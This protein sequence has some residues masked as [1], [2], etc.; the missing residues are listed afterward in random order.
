MVAKPAVRLGHAGHQRPLEPP[1]RVDEA[2]ELLPE[3]CT[4]CHTVFPD[5]LPTVAD[6]RRTQVWELP[7]VPPHLTEYRQ[8]TR[9]CPACRQLVTA[10]LPADAPPGGFGPRATALI[11]LLRGRF[12]LSL[13]DTV[14]CLT[15]LWHLPLCAASVVTRCARV[16]AALAPLDAAIQD[17]VQ[18]APV[19]NADETSWPTE[20]R[21]GWLWVAVSATATCFRIHPSRSGPAL[22][23]LLGEAYYGIVGS[24]R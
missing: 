16:S 6:P 5:D 7:V 8:H 13:D 1:E 10:E 19:V 15:E 4:A 11:A 3:R 18:L 20:T 2:I 23:A 17:A 9:C 22:R 12:R 14:A 24:D 21:R